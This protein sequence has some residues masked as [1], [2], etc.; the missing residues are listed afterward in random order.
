MLVKYSP[1]KGKTVSKWKSRGWERALEIWGHGLGFC[2]P[3]CYFLLTFH[4]FFRNFIFIT[5]SGLF[6][7]SKNWIWRSHDLASLQPSPLC[8]I[9]HPKTTLS[10]TSNKKSWYQTHKCEKRNRPMLQLQTGPSRTRVGRIFSS[11]SMESLGIVQRLWF[12]LLQV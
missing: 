9:L 12:A 3:L 6:N 8:L 10:V 7:P 1:M 11:L 2:H 5:T 4:W